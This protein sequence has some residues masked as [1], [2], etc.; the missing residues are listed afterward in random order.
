MRSLYYCIDLDEDM[1]IVLGIF[2]LFA[3][4]GLV[5][6]FMDRFGRDWIDG[7]TNFIRLI[8]SK[9]VRK[10]SRQQTQFLLLMSQKLSRQGN[11]ELQFHLK[12]R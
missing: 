2:V 11:T 4:S 9:K 5:I 7:F 3:I 6:G 10:P 8:S 12:E 1:S